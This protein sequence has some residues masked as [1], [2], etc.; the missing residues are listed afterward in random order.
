MSFSTVKVFNT[1]CMSIYTPVRV[2]LILLL[3]SL[4][5]VIESSGERLV[6]DYSLSNYVRK[7]ISFLA[8]DYAQNYTQNF[9]YLLS[10]PAYKPH[11]CN[12]EKRREQKPVTVLLLGDSIDRNIVFDLCQSNPNY[13]FSTNWANIAIT[14]TFH[15]PS[16]CCASPEFLVCTAHIYG[17][18]ARGPYQHGYQNNAEDPHVDTK[19]RIPQCMGD[20]IA[21]FGHPN[22]ILFRTEVW[23]LK[24]TMEMKTAITLREISNQFIDDFLVDLKL[25]RH[26]SPNALLGT[27]TVPKITW[28]MDY[29]YTY[30]N[31]MRYLSEEV[32]IFIYLYVCMY[33]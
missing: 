29:F 30:L 7:I 18:A 13:N 23:D 6:Q 14:K 1:T 3:F 24:M 17:S 5:V 11:H 8:A 33:V 28:G 16:C 31:A 10:S 19:L 32:R 15:T 21:Q 9:D 12:V 22:F 27:H 25:I 20:Y 4:V 2:Y 26:L